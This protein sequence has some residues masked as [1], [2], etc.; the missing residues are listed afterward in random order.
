MVG[1][2][3]PQGAHMASSTRGSSSSMAAESG[4]E[5]LLVTTCT[6]NH[7][8]T[9]LAV[10]SLLLSNRFNCFFLACIVLYI[11]LL[12]QNNGSIT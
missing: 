6:R 5:L 1:R 12:E 11:V 10:F 8:L 2:S 3:N 9:P 4:L 7:D